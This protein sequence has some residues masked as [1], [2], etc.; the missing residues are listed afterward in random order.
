MLGKLYEVCEQF[1]GDHSVH[2]VH[3]QVQ[4]ELHDV[5]GKWVHHESQRV[6]S[7]GHDQFFF[8]LGRPRIDTFLHDAAAVLVASYG[9]TL[10]AHDVVDE[11][12]L[13]VARGPDL[14]NLLNNVIAV[15]VKAHRDEA[16]TQEIA[17]LF[18]L[19]RFSNHLNHFLDASRA[20]RIK[21]DL[22]RITSYSVHDDRG[23]LL[24]ATVLH[25]LLDEVVSEAVVHEIE[26]AHH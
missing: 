5:V 9:D 20:V 7:Y 10:L 2:L 1:F 3:A 8:L 16:R 19:L 23:Q 6:L 18:K 24:I 13:V 14:E 12:V 17:K 25:K 26:A 22:E 21:A 15:D 11:L 4:N